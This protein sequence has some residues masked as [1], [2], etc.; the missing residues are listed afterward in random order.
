MS[1]GK[2]TVLCCACLCNG[3]RADPV[4]NPPERRLKAVKTE[5]ANDWSWTGGSKAEGAAATET[6]RRAPRSKF[7]RQVRDETVRTGGRE[8]P[9]DVRGEHLMATFGLRAVQHGNWV[10]DEHAAVHLREACGALHDMSDLLG[11]APE[12]IAQGGLAKRVDVPRVAQLA[13]EHAAAA[14]GEAVSVIQDEIR[15]AAAGVQF[16]ASPDVKL[17]HAAIQSVITTQADDRPGTL[18]ALRML[19]E[20]ATPAVAPV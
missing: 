9:S 17:L 2:A 20:A 7:Q 19:R 16:R 15:D 4:R 12:K 14:H 3:H 1:Q 11:I 6:A 18:R 5:A 13:A 10:A 8:V